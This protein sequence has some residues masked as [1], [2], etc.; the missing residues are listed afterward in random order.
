MNFIKNFI[1]F[2]LTGDNIPTSSNR[3]NI[4]NFQG[5][6]PNYTPYNHNNTDTNVEEYN[7]PENITDPVENNT[8]THNNYPRNL[9]NTIDFLNIGSKM[10][11]G[12]RQID[13][14]SNKSHIV[15][16]VVG[17]GV[18]I[19]DELIPTE[20]SKNTLCWSLA[21]PNGEAMTFRT[22]VYDDES[23]QS[24]FQ[25]IVK[26]Y[27]GKIL[28]YNLPILNV[29]NHLRQLFTRKKFLNPVPLP[30]HGAPSSSAVSSENVIRSYNDRIHNF[31]NDTIQN[32]KRDITKAD[33]ARNTVSNDIYSPEIVEN[34]SIIL[35]KK[36]IANEMHGNH[37]YAYIHVPEK[38]VKYISEPMWN[39]PS[40]AYYINE[41]RC[42]NYNCIELNVEVLDVRY[43][44]NK[45]Q[46]RVSP[47]VTYTEY[48]K[49]NGCRSILKNV[50]TDKIISFKKGYGN[51]VR[52]ETTL[53]EILTYLKEVLNFDY[54]TIV[55]LTC[56]DD[57]IDITDSLIHNP[58][59]F[60]INQ[61]T[62]YD[63]TADHYANM[64]NKANK[65]MKEVN[66]RSFGGSKRR[67][68]RRTTRVARRIT[69]YRGVGCKTRRKKVNA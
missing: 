10:S 30:N 4:D 3:H 44:K 23:N 53:T 57:E 24:D 67:Q 45:D 48:E 51:E 9:D 50:V 6:S 58:E 68:R 35:A 52:R 1:K 66:Y 33:D 2:S 14:D 12:I 62:A 28:S 26:N 22:S 46:S 29:L 27:V 61:G 8:I 64:R 63:V 40:G 21:S 56:R 31:T 16:S 34:A 13:P 19:R 20:L 55:E 38:N 69:Q 25:N 32:F 59:S 49:Y 5:I 7:K 54:V 18:V 65:Y 42:V 11:P 47:Y 37:K 60:I 43:P 15:I 17:H 36:I 39:I 41:F